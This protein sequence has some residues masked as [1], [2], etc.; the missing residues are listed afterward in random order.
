MVTFVAGEPDK[1]Y[2]RRFHIKRLNTPN[3]FAML[4]EIMERRLIHK[5][6]LLPDLFVLDGGRPQL[7][8]IITVFKKYYIS[9]PLIGL[10]KADE[11]LVIPY[12]DKF[13]KIKLAADSPA[14]NLM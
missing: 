3:D 2:Y 6:L 11:E 10:A 7:Q 14:L 12:G 8:K 1:N 4:E 9:I 5:N 13:I